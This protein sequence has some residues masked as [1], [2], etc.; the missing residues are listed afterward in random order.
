[1]LAR[2]ANDP[3]IH[4]AA[5]EFDPSKGIKEQEDIFLKLAYSDY[6]YSDNIFRDC[7]VNLYS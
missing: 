2:S 6:S 1:M 3:E 7:D 5:E 4:A